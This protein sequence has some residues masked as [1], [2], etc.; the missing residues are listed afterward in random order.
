[1]ICHDCRNSAHSECRGGTW[2]ACQHRVEQEPEA[3]AAEE[4]HVDYTNLIQRVW[5]NVHRMDPRWP[6][7]RPNTQH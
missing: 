7:P 5:D 4:P 3:E 2:C 1:M 6:L